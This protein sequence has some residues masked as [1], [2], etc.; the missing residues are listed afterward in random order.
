MCAWIELGDLQPRACLVTG[1]KSPAMAAI[2][3]FTRAVPKVQNY[4]VISDFVTPAYKKTNNT[5]TNNSHS[6]TRSFVST[7]ALGLYIRAPKELPYDSDVWRE[8]LS[9]GVIPF[10]YQ[11]IARS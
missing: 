7:P 4:V 6:L 3:C 1:H 8:P 11:T 5:N 10:A 9:P 2:D